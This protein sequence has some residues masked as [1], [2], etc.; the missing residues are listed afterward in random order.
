MCSVIYHTTR[1]DGDAQL[2]LACPCEGAED[3]PQLVLK[4]RGMNAGEVRMPAP[5]FR[6][7]F[8]EEDIRKGGYYGDL[9]VTYLHV[10]NGPM[11]CLVAIHK[12]GRADRIDLATT[13]LK[14]MRR[15]FLT[16]ADIEPASAQPGRGR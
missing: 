15:A 8:V 5:V 10:P 6:M 4:Q 9:D 11:T 2:K 1:A 3:V 7:L 12:G 14:G 16:K 13:V